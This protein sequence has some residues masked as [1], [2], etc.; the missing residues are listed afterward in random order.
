MSSLNATD[1]RNVKVK[2]ELVAA[3]PMKPGLKIVAIEKLTKSIETTPTNSTNTSPSPSNATSLTPKKTNRRKS[4]LLPMAHDGDAIEFLEETRD[5]VDNNIQI[6]PEIPAPPPTTIARDLNALR[7]G[8]RV[9]NLDD[10]PN[11]N[12]ELMRRVAFLRVSIQHTLKELD[13]N[14]IKFEASQSA[15]NLRTQYIQNKRIKE[16]N[17]N[18]MQ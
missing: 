1:Y 11:P 5:I 14:P 2:E 4:A 15:S 7:A 10:V 6:P 8:H 18:S 3:A 17:G 16:E 13:I 9:L 12:I